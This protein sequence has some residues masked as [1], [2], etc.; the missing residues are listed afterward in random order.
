VEGAAIICTTT[1]ASEPVLQGQ[2]VA[3]GAHINAIGASTPGFRELDT[4]AVVQSR[5]F[6]DRRESAL[7]EADDIRLPLRDGLVGE[8]HILGELGDVLLGRAQGR[9]SP[10]DV[11]LFKSLGLAVEDLAAAHY[12]YTRGSAQ[13]IGAMVEFAGE[14]H[15]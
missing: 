12:V 5:V 13:G 7:N 8:D 3:P 9:T 15:D 11:T 6:V 14:R 1:M 4:A 2:W 10:T